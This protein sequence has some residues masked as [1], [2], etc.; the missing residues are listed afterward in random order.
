[1]KK[2]KIIQILILIAL[3]AVPLMA[4]AQGG[5]T[6]GIHIPAGLQPEGVTHLPIEAGPQGEAV[7]VNVVLQLIAGSLIY[8]AGPVAI[9]MLAFGGTQYITAH[10]DQ[11]Q[12]EGAKKTITWALIGMAVII[13]SYAIV[14]NIINMLETVVSGT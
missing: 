6:P 7:V 3:T 11:N 13:V 2:N 8:L 14:W 1:M 12:L 4:F 10:G 9:L 5:G